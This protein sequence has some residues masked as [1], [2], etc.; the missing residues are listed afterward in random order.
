PAANVRSALAFVAEGAAPLGI[1]Y[2]TDALV[3]SKV[4]IV[5][6]FP[7]DTHPPIVYPAGLVTGRAGPEARAYLAF[8]Q[9]PKARAI[10]SRYGFIVLGRTSAGGR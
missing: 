6:L 3:S 1:V 5:G 7:D 4:R 10:F 8:L 9:G 2:D